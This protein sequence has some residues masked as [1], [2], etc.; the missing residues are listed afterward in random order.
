MRQAEQVE[1]TLG[2]ALV[3]HHEEARETLAW[4]AGVVLG[5]AAVAL[6]FR[7]RTAKWARLVTVI[8]TLVVLAI[9]FQAGHSGGVL[10]F[11]KGANVMRTTGVRG[12]P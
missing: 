2:E 1:A 5:V 7:D 8:G 11:T 10:V 9:A 4:A 6:F 12:G 3:E